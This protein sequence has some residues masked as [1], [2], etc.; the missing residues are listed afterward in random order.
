MEQVGGKRGL[1]SPR[2]NDCFARRLR[3]CMDRLALVYGF[4]TE[5]VT[6]K[7]VLAGVLRG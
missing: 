2:W 7:T 4:A 3:E 5:G 6:P 1:D